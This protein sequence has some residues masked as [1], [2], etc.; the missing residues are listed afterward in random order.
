MKYPILIFILFTSSIFSQSVK[1][2]QFKYEFEE[3]VAVEEYKNFD[4]KVF[5]SV[6]KSSIPVDLFVVTPKYA[7]D[8]FNKPNGKILHHFDF[9]HIKSFPTGHVKGKFKVKNFKRENSFTYVSRILVISKGYSPHDVRSRSDQT[10]LPPSEYFLHPIPPKVYGGKDS[11]G[12]R[13]YSA[14]KKFPLDNHNPA[15]IQRA[16]QYTIWVL[17]HKGTKSDI[18]LSVTSC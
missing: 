11:I 1:D 4:L 8:F 13:T 17:L 10:T 7:K 14:E 15:G 2:K 18:G 16:A 12:K 3:L 6:N 5:D 9:K